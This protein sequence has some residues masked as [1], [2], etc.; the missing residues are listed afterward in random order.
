MLNDKLPT[1]WTRQM[2]WLCMTSGAAGHTYGAN[3][4]WQVN[5]PGQPHGP[6]PHHPP[7]SSGYGVIPWNEAMNLPGSTHVSLGKKFF[8]QFHWQRFTP[9]NDWAVYDIP[10]DEL[11]KSYGPFATGIAEDDLRIIYV[12]ES[13]PLRVT[14]LKPDASYRAQAFDPT[15]GKTINLGM[16]AA[17]AKSGW[18]TVKPPAC[19]ADDWVLILRRS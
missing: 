4:I 11:K 7:G 18:T 16:I 17:D 14:N 2:F 15:S 9:H 1:Q 6:S 19:E 8:E 10:P 5:R 3:G 12:P 13:H